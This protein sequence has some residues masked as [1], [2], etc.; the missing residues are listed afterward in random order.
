MLD[1]G[2]G[3]GIVTH[4]FYEAG[5]RPR[6]TFA[7]DLSFNSLKIAREEF[8]KNEHVEAENVC[9][10]QG[11]ILSLPFAENTFD[12]ILSCGVLEYVSIEEGL[13]EL[14]R[15]LKPASN[16]ILIPIRPSLVGS[17]LEK[18]YDFKTHSIEETEQIAEQYF[19]ITG[20]YEFPITEPIGW[21]KIA[22][23]FRNK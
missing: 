18:L 15:I 16:L 20:K 10:V 9:A 11:N 22:F 7:V 12:L 3:T 14:A 6:R 19:E 21:S 5:Y 17:I 2:S 13:R 8:G 1:A 23:L 4:G